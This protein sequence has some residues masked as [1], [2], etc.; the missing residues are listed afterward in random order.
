MTTFNISYRT[1]DFFYNSIDINGR[2]VIDT[3][4]FNLS[5]VIVWASEVTRKDISNFSNATNIFDLSLSNVIIDPKNDFVNTFL[6]GNIVFNNNFLSSQISIESQVKPKKKLS[7]EA[8]IEFD[9]NGLKK[10]TNVKNPDG[11]TSTIYGD[12]EFQRCNV[13]E[14]CTIKHLHFSC[15]TQSVDGDCNCVCTGPAVYDNTPHSHC[16]TFTNDIKDPEQAIVQAYKQKS[17][18]ANWATTYV[19]NE[20][21]SGSVKIEGNNAFIPYSNIYDLSNNSYLIRQLIYDYY[22]EV[23]KNK[24]Y[25][26]KL[27]N[28]INIYSKNKIAAMDSSVI[29]KT[30]YVNVFNIISGIFIVSGYIYINA[31]K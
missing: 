25:M 27:S 22:V 2:G 7:T 1:T 10:Q 28:Q 13:R 4:P 12:A 3:F 20:Y 16:T 30:N 26:E 6:P 5:N 11:G 18:L 19:R 31:I 21:K 15:S 23:N 8:K 14:V 9:K 17:G 24:K 29:Y